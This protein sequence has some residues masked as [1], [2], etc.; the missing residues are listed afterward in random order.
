MPNKSPM[1]IADTTFLQH[2]QLL[3]FNGVLHLSVA[4][5]AQLP[6]ASA[7]GSRRC[8]CL[9]SHNCPGLQPWEKG[10]KLQ[11]IDSRS[12]IISSFCPGL[13]PWAIMPR[14]HIRSGWHNRVSFPINSIMMFALMLHIL[15]KSTEASLVESQCRVSILPTE[16]RKLW[17]SPLDFQ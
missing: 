2:L 9:S 13:K 3:R 14:K 16:T 5:F 12:L 8:W 4:V 17:Y 10:A 15:N 6:R 11:L 7:L 1:L